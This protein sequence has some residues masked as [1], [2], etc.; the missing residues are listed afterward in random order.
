VG[1]SSWYPTLPESTLTMT[2]TLELGGSN[3]SSECPEVMED[4]FEVSK[5]WT[6]KKACKVWFIKGDPAF[7]PRARLTTH[8][9]AEVKAGEQI[10]TGVCT[11]KTVTTAEEEVQGA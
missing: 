11:V 3:T 4:T 9:P 10:I 8:T 7:T 6:A 1:K 5:S 2:Q